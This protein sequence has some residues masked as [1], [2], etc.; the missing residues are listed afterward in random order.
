M[1][2]KTVDENK[3]KAIRVI[4]NAQVKCNSNTINLWKHLILE[5]DRYIGLPIFFPIFKHF[6][7]IGYRFWKKTITDIFLFVIHDYTE[8]NQQWNVLSVFDPSKCTHTWSSGQCLL[9]RSSSAATACNFIQD[10]LVWNTLTY[11]NIYYRIV[12]D[13]YWFFYSRYRLFV[14]LCTQ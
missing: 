7:I 6:T 5:I 3:N 14:C 10:S 4:R 2:E 9:R 12:I 13:Q 11:I 1:A 8:Y